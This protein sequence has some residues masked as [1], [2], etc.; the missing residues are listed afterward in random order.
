MN[1]NHIC[2]T[3]ISPS[4]P[5]A[6]LISAVSIKLRL[7]FLLS[8]FA[9]AAAAATN[10]APANSETECR[11]AEMDSARVLDQS[12]S[13]IVPGRQLEVRLKQFDAWL[14]CRQQG[15]VPMPTL[16]LDHVARL[17]VDALIDPGAKA[18]RYPLR[19]NE[20]NRSIWA[21]ASATAA[22]EQAAA[23]GLGS[24][25][26]ELSVRT[27]TEIT[28]EGSP[29]PIKLPCQIAVT[30]RQA[31][32]IGWVYIACLVVISV[33]I[34]WLTRLVR[35]R[36]VL[37]P[38]SAESGRPYSLARTQLLLWTVT[39]AGV[40][41]YL[42]ITTGML[43]NLDVEILALLGISAGTSGAA[44]LIEG[45]AADLPPVTPTAGFFL[46][47]LL[48]DGGGPSVHRLQAVLANTGLAI[49]FAAE[50]IHML[51]FYPISPSWAAL[52]ALSS[53][54]YLGLK[55]GESK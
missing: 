33:L 48:D 15:K 50:S 41:G 39:V 30:D 1:R 53:G 9:F 23:V 44:G 42:W 6:R 24:A 18:V 27:D 7:G 31:K 55:A 13:L 8:A 51:D 52:L 49:I 3:R 20:K 34:A 47:D 25:V 21:M 40:G 38:G 46:R 19:V 17:D 37:A 26:A 29:K 32:R 28:A 5:D 35:D 11:P 36:G 10:T 4:L 45:R 43:P 16:Y 12:P 54:V 22:R 14:V 2:D